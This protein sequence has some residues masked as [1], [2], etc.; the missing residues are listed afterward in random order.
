VGVTPA[1]LAGKMPALQIESLI[2]TLFLS[3][4]T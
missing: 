1:S 4:S 2:S 3:F